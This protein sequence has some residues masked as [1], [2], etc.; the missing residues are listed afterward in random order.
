[1]ESKVFEITVLKNTFISDSCRA[2]QQIARTN[3]ERTSNSLEVLGDL[4]RKNALKH[5]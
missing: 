3:A 2:N 1:M 4:A 5:A